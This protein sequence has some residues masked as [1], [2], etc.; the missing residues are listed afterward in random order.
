M[1]HRS[2]MASM[3]GVPKEN[4]QVI[5]RFLG[6]GFGGKGWP[7]PQA[8]LAAACARNL[9]K[10]VKLVVS[11][12]MMFQSVGHRPVVDQR[13][14]LA[15]TNEG[16]L[17]VVAQDYVN[18]TS[19][20]DDYNESCGE[21][22]GFMYSTPN[23]L[24]TGGHARRNVGTP[25][26][27]RGP[28]AVPGIYALESAMDEL[29]VKLKMDPVQLRVLNEPTEDEESKKPFSSRHLKECLSV[30]AEK[31]GWSKRNPAIG[32]MRNAD[33][34]I[35]GWGMA[36]CSW[37]A[38][39]FET[40]ASVQIRRDGTARVVCGTQ[41]IGTGT[42]TVIAQLVSHETGLPLN[43]IEVVIGDSSLPPG[44][45]S[46]GSAVTAS[47]VPAILQAAQNAV[48]S[49]L[50]VATTFPSSPFNGK[51]A[52]DLE[53]A[54][55]VVRLKA[56]PSTSLQVGDIVQKA[57]LESVN[58]DG[59]SAA[60]F[61][62]GQ[63]E[64]FHSFGAQFVEVTWRPEIAELRVSRVVS[65]MDVGKI[66]NPT[67]ARNQVEGAIV[68]G[69]G[70]ALL[71]GNEYDQR[72]GAPIN[73]NLAD[74]IVPVNAD[75]PHI[76]ITFVEYPDYKLNPAGARGVGE[77]GLAGVAPAIAS[78]IYHATG[79]RVRHLPIRIEDL[80]TTT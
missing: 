5:T 46:G 55:G 61:G 45:L 66:M 18:H 51:R 40:E 77:I 14:Q 6:S 20:V 47:I 1:N 12:S 16:K 34:V 19:M 49:L 48:R 2:V 33:G 25:G 8:F 4:V 62:F 72:S 17:T 21:A 78:A 36:S 7:W 38:I 73:S 44:P 27:M 59:K 53:M 39:R 9:G 37:Q 26:P 31:F 15:S 30:G 57:K 43:K 65:V 67:T 22:T 13:I 29:A 28:G 64:S 11:R 60:V 75:C 70:M 3:L 71:E 32:S 23:L 80:L 69:V 42:Y 50:N 68:M 74:Y 54:D 79:T 10:P 58:G 52:A 76:D 56:Q 41:D 35:V 24:V 63:K